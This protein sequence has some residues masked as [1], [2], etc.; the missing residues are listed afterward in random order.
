MEAYYKLDSYA[1]FGYCYPLRIFK[2]E[3]DL[4][5]DFSNLIGITY[6][7][8]KIE[9]D[10]N[11]GTPN[12]I[13]EFSHTDDHKLELNLIK[14]KYYPDATFYNK[15]YYPTIYVTNLIF[16]RFAYQLPIRISKE[17]FYS[18]YQNLTV[19]STQ[20]VD[21]SA[22]SLFLMLDTAKGDNVN[23]MIK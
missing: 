20:F 15:I 16:E 21:N 12:L 5:I 9:I 8:I 22:N 17:S 10:F 6:P 1:G 18:N 13:E 19:A 14:H 3:T 4:V 11:D 2:G 7:L 23:L